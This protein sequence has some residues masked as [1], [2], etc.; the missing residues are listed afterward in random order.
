MFHRFIPKDKH[1]LDYKAFREFLF[2]HAVEDTTWDQEYNPFK[3][4]ER[5]GWKSPR[6]CKE[7]R[8]QKIAHP[9]P[10]R[11]LS[12]RLDKDPSAEPGSPRSSA[13]PPPSSR[14]PTRLERNPPVRL[15]VTL[16]NMLGE[17]GNKIMQEM[18]RL[19]G[20]RQMVDRHL[21]AQVF[22]NV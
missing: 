4:G 1:K 16:E 12:G 10:W 2:Q 14:P 20:G 17:H 8:R 18:K 7:A 3:A 15:P 19:N 5:E 21:C 6:L 13:L 11:R 22:A 9:N